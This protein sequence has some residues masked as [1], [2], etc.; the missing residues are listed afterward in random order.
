MTATVSMRIRVVALVGLLA[1]LLLGAGTFMMSRS[2]TDPG[3]EPSTAAVVEK[4]KPNVPSAEAEAAPAAKA[5]AKA[6]SPVTKP[7]A[8]PA[9]P[10]TAPAVDI[11]T[12]LPA[13]VAKALQTHEVV[14]LSLVS[15]GSAVDELAAA[16]A[17]AG[18]KRAGV[19]FVKITVA[20]RKDLTRLT[21]ELQVRH[22]PSVLVF[23]RPDRLFVQ[24]KGFADRDTVAQA[25]TNAS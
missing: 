25:A 22:T 5:E 19:G 14:V 2:S 4:P 15:P 24:V 18:A 17:S 13:P 7:Q 8:A 9:S 16:E 23:T 12:G 6:A 20:D 10:E 1:A 21:A 3:S 11:A